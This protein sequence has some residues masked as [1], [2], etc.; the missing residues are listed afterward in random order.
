MNR[1]SLEFS[2][3]YDNYI[4]IFNGYCPSGWSHNHEET[5][6]LKCAVVCCYCHVGTWQSLTIADC[7]LPIDKAVER[8]DLALCQGVPGFCNPDVVPEQQ[9]EEVV[10]AEELAK[11]SPMHAQLMERKRCWSVSRVA[12]CVIEV[13]HTHFKELTNDLPPL[14]EPENGSLRQHYPSF[15]RLFL[16]STHKEVY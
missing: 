10:V 8:I 16:T 14:S 13:S 1:L 2:V 3:I 7:G 11:V 15:R 12:L 6:T 9:V 4:A 5:Q